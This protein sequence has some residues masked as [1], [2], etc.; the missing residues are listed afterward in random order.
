MRMFR[1]DAAVLGINRADE[2]CSHALRRG[3]ARDILM[4]AARWPRY[5]AQEFNLVQ[6]SLNICFS[7]K[8]KSALFFVC[9]LTTRTQSRRVLCEQYKPWKHKQNSVCAHHGP[10]RLQTMG[11]NERWA[12]RSLTKSRQGFKIGSCCNLSQGVSRSGCF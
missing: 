8:W 6:L 1:H 9:S 11:Y 3:M 10:Q 12:L 7:A 5:C 4:L 2:I